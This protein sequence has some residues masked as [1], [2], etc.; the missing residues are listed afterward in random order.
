M[1][2]KVQKPWSRKFDGSSDVAIVALCWAPAALFSLLM[3][4]WM[5]KVVLVAGAGGFLWY[6][7]GVRPLRTSDQIPR[8][9]HAFHFDHQWNADLHNLQGVSLGP[10]VE[11][12]SKRWRY[13]DWEVYWF[14]VLYVSGMAV[15]NSVLGAVEHVLYSGDFERTELNESPIFILGH[16][17]TGTTH[18][19][20]LLSQDKEGFIFPSTL[21]CGFPNGM[22]VLHNHQR[23]LAGFLKDTRPMDNMALGLE[24]PQE[25]ELALMHLSGGASPYMPMNFMTCEP[26]F[27]Q[28]FNFEEASEQDTNRWVEALFYFLRKVTFVND[29]FGKSNP[30]AQ[31]QGRRLVIKSPCHV[32]RARLFHQLFPKAQFVYIHRH[33]Y[34]VW[35]SAANMAQKTYW[36]FYFAK[37]SDEAITEFILK[38]YEVLFEDYLKAKESIPSDQFYEIKYQDLS[39]DCLGTLEKLYKHFGWTTWDSSAK[40]NIQRYLGTLKAFKKNKFVPIPEPMRAYVYER[41]K[42][43]F[44]AFGY[45]VEHGSAD[46]L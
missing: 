30:P 43:S 32:S 28:Y 16:P 25:D 37:P 27:R 24:M 4:P 26:E 9:T 1:T 12:L 29:Y 10:W 7:G 31:G 21:Q 42:P 3:L 5:Y 36:Y 18:L 17:R 19:H 46:E 44:E 45:S 20:N 23:R 38:Q 41:W 2:L 22:T 39:E 35:K 33:P 6:H 8:V 13:I 15:L 40:A 11:L 34:A 14:R